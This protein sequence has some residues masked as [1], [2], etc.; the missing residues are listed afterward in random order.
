VTIGAADSP[1]CFRL[2]TDALGTP[3]A[4][5]TTGVRGGMR[6]ARSTSSR[7]GR[8]ASH[9]RQ[10]LV[11]A[12][13]S[14]AAARS[15]LCHMPARLQ[16]GC[17]RSGTCLTTNAT[18]LRTVRITAAVSCASSR[19]GANGTSSDFEGS[20]VAV[21]KTSCPSRRPGTIQLLRRK[22]DSRDTSAATG[23][24]RPSPIHR[25]H[26]PEPPE[27]RVSLGADRPR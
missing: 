13:T 6:P 10:E 16:C 20:T 12:H 2:H 5:V 23:C 11:G 1:R 8:L 7:A 4:E 9:V 3:P 22:A 18:T 27:S 17:S 19:T 25:R 15:L 24:R 26:S 21:L 14:P